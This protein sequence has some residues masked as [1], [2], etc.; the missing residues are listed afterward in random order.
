MTPAIVKCFVDESS[1]YPTHRPLCIEVPTRMLEAN[2]KELQRPI[3][4]ASMF[5][6]RIE[7]ELETAV[8]K[9]EDEILK[10]NDAFQ[11][12]Q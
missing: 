3:N 4:F 8:K 2:V 7:A 12:E 11:G 5:E 10:G 6:Q 9:K 1:D